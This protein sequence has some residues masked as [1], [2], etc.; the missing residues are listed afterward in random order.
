M[1][2]YERQRRLIDQALDHLA[3]PSVPASRVLDECIRLAELRR[4]LVNLWWLRIES[5][6]IEDKREMASLDAEMALAFSAEVWKQVREKVLLDHMERRRL[7]GEKDERLV[8][9]E[10]LQELETSLAGLVDLVESS[11][12]A[13]GLHPQDLYFAIESHQKVRARTQAGIHG[14]RVILGRV[15]TRLV[16][17]LAE[18]ESALEFGKA[19][20][21]AF[22]RVRNVVDGLLTQIAPDALAKFKAANE[23][24]AA[25]D[26]EA[27]SQALASCRRILVSLADSLYPATNQIIKGGDGIERVMSADKYRNRLWQ[28]I[29]GKVPHGGSRRLMQA[30]LGEIGDRLDILDHI[31]SKGVH[32]DVT[33]AE[34]DQCVVQ[35]YMLA[36]D[37]LRLSQVADSTPGDRG[38][39]PGEA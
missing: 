36:G 33:A 2:T 22:E 23:R 10:S 16:R 8:S 26:P 15:R 19:A 20:T 25:G 13:S 11:K 32:G 6:G 24:A 34:V 38:P 5:F 21:D 35:V 30:T 37:L 7:A 9:A 12:P 18:T 27:G 3:D 28:F 17:F 14:R 29:N 39:L 4:D 31:A 1:L